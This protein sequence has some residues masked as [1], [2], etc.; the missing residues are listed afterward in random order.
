MKTI[1]LMKTIYF[2]I[3]DTDIG[4]NNFKKWHLNLM[5]YF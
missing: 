5:G 4:R 1:N 2:I 3:S